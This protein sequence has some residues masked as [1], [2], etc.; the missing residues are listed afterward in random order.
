LRGSAILRY[1][2]I[3]I[4]KSFIQQSSLVRELVTK[5]TTSV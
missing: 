3:F 2:A 1:S 5:I 4:Q